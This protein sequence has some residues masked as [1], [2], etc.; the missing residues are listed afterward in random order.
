MLVIIE[1]PRESKTT[2]HWSSA[3]LL[4]AILTYEIDS[5]SVG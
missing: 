2:E 5:I 1:N 3:R 4:Y